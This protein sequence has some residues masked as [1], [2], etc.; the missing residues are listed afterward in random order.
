MFCCGYWVQGFHIQK[1]TRATKNLRDKSG[2]R[3]LN[4]IVNTGQ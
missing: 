1:S 2:V 4:L 3:N